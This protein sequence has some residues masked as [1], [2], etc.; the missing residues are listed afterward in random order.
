MDLN[1]KSTSI[2][3]R[4]ISFLILGVIFMTNLSAQGVIE[5]QKPAE[6]SELSLEQ[7]LFQSI[8][9]GDMAAFSQLLKAGADINTADPLYKNQTPLILAAW[10]GRTEIVN[11]LINAGA[12]ID[13]RD[14]DGNSALLGASFRADLGLIKSLVAAGAEINTYNKKKETPLHIAASR[15]RPALAAYLLQLGAPIDVKDAEGNTP[16]KLSVE[17][18]ASSCVELLLDLGADPDLTNDEGNSARSLG[19]QTKNESIKSVFANLRERELLKLKQIEEFVEAAANGNVGAVSDLYK[20]G[21]KINAQNSEGL[22]AFY[23]ALGMSRLNVVQWL[24]QADVDVTPLSIDGLSPLHVAVSGSDYALIRLLIASGINT[25]V[26]DKSGETALVYAC[27]NGLNSVI[28]ILIENGANLDVISKNGLSPKDL[29]LS[30]GNHKTVRLLT[31]FENGGQ[32]YALFKAV[33]S[34]DLDAVTA[35]LESGAPTDLW[36]ENDSTVLGWAT[37]NNDR[38]MLKL[39]FAHGVDWQRGIGDKTTLMIAAMNGQLDTL[40]IVLEGTGLRDLDA[41]DKVGKTALYLALENDHVAITEYLMQ[42]PRSAFCYP[43]NLYSPVMLAMQRQHLELARKL[44]KLPD[45][46]WLLVNRDTN[47]RRHLFSAAKYGDADLIK[48][49]IIITANPNPRNCDLKTPLFIAV[50]QGDMERTKALLDFGANLHARDRFGRTAFDYAIAKGYKDLIPLLKPI[51]TSLEY[52]LHQSVLVNDLDTLRNLIDEDVDVN[53]P[54]RRG[55]TALLKAISRFNLDATHILLG[56]GADANARDAR[57]ANAW[58]YASRLGNNKDSDYSA[59]SNSVSSSSPEN[60][61]RFDRQ[62]SGIN[63]HIEFSEQILSLFEGPYSTIEYRLVM[64]RG[65][66]LLMY[67]TF[68]GDRDLVR[69]CVA[70][71]GNIYDRD[72]Q[73]RNAMDWALLGR[74]DEKFREYMTLI[75]D[76]PLRM[77]VP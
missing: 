12:N 30:L 73:G 16:L 51:A 8:D 20:L 22:T 63:S 72:N 35:L 36:D 19:E 1:M 34:G 28:E 6:N 68:S 64:E 37:Q 69:C 59:I 66:S 15:N 60:N 58:V 40:K 49:I 76:N 67:A 46:E 23:A 53:F 7:Q 4:F 11:E 75:A 17:L 32:A 3:F 5:N 38:E 25:E 18:E 57:G 14:D 70:D 29:A 45:S 27:R 74:Q 41:T 62:G 50:E 52:Q 61:Q 10:W 48:S 55:V 2:T 47:G 65:I 54:D 71:G 26:Q 24:I 42:W 33:K 9:R 13:A 39:L 43:Y 21:V 31:L 77:D 56:A 44:L